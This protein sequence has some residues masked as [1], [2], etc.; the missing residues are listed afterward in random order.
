MLRSFLAVSLTWAPER[1]QISLSGSLLRRQGLFEGNCWKRT[2][3][4]CQR[5]LIQQRSY[6]HVDVVWLNIQVSYQPV[7]NSTSNK[8]KDKQIWKVN[9]EISERA[10]QSKHLMEHRNCKERWCPGLCFETVLLLWQ[11]WGPSHSNASD[12]VPIICSLLIFLLKSLIY[13]IASV[14]AAWE[15]SDWIEGA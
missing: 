6:K 2:K 11:Y 13:H 8:S 7:G 3:K 5:G 1:R 12:R 4:A 15:G 9:P 14:L 10:V